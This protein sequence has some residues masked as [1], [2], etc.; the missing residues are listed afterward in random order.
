MSELLIENVGTIATGRLTAPTVDADSIYVRDGVI[1]E[2]DATAATAE[3]VIDARGTTVVPGI[4]D[5]HVHPVAGEYTPRQETIGWCESYLNS[6][7]TSMVSAGEIHHPGRPTDAE[8]LKSLAT[9]NRKSYDNLRPSGV[10]LH[11]GTLILTNDTTVDDIEAVRDRGVS[12]TKIIFAMDDLDHASRLVERAK[13]LGMVT[14]MHSGGS[15]V[16]GTRPIDEEMFKTIRPDIALHFN[17]GPTALPDDEWRA[18]V[19]DTDIDLELVIAGNQRTA[20]EILETMAERGELDRL[21]IATDTPT[22]TGVVPCGMWLEAGILASLTE[23]SAPEIVSLMTGVPARRHGLDV[24]R[25]EE[26]RPA[27]L[28]IVDA[29]QGSAGA[30]ALGAV[31]NGDYPSVDTVVVDGEILVKTSDNTGPAKRPAEIDP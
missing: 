19:E 12:R 2:L 9:L 30:D 7:T 11:A 5:A 29:P 25:I 13:E 8:G 24:G 3:T 20:I 26:G 31:S 4:V 14:M 22:G 15:S 28:C 16:P 10:K 17:G 21:Q 18:I 6:G 27:D 23:V 1:E